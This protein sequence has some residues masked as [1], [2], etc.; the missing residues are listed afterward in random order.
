MQCYHPYLEGTVKLK[1]S[2]H[3]PK[4]T[5]VGRVGVRPLNFKTG[6]LIQLPASSRMMISIMVT[7]RHYS[8][9]NAF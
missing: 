5:Q 2:S 4:P 1:E 9:L 8:I 6:L 7:L 3:L